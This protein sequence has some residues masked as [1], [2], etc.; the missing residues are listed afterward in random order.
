[1]KTKLRLEMKAGYDG[2]GIPTVMHQDNYCDQNAILVIPDDLSYTLFY[3]DTSRFSVSILIKYIC[4]TV[5]EYWPFWHTLKY[6]SSPQP[7]SFLF[8]L[9][10]SRE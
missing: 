3:Q 1:M 2:I 4:K 6:V 7:P 10:A 5:L 9:E 8:S